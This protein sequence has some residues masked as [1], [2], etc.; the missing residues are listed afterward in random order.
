MKGKKKLVI[1]DDYDLNLGLK[2]TFHS[3]RILDYGIQIA[4]HNKI[5]NYSSMNYILDDIVKLSKAYQRSELWEMIDVKYRK[6]FNSKS[7]LFKDLCPKDLNEANKRKA[8][9]NLFSKYGLNNQD[10]INEI[11][12]IL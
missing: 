3:L 6:L 8:L 4:E 5:I 9:E 11:L 12:Q 2:S 10:L 1:V 7:S